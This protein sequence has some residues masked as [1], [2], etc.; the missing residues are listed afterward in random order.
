MEMAQPARK[1][2]LR[3]ATRT[4]APDRP[5]MT[6]VVV[7]MVALAIL[8]PYLLTFGRHAP[9]WEET[10]VVLAAANIGWGVSWLMRRGGPITWL[11]IIKW[12]GLTALAGLALAFAAAATIITLYAR[13]L[14]SIKKLSDYQPKQVTVILDDKGERIGEIFSG[15]PPTKEHR[16]ERRTLVPFDKIPKRVYQAFIATEDEHFWTH[17]GVDYMGIVR[18]AL[19]DLRGGRKEGASTITQQVVK[20]LVL[21]PERT[22][23]RKIQEMILARRLEQHLTKQEILTIYLNE[24]YLGNQRY[25]IEEAARFYFGKDV[26]GTGDQALDIG[27]AAMLAG[28]PKSPEHYAPP[29]DF[30]AHPRQAQAAK[31]RQVHVLKRELDLHMISQADY[32]K[33]RKAPIQI[34]RDPFPKLGSAPEWVEKAREEL[35][36]SYGAG[37]VERMGAEVKTTLDSD[38]QAHAQHALVDGLRAYDHRHHLGQAIHTYKPDRKQGWAPRLERLARQLPRHGPTARHVYKAL[39]LGARDREDEVDVDLGNWP[40]VLVLGGPEDDRFNPPD[41]HGH[42]KSASQR[43]KAGDLIQVVTSKRRPKLGGHAVELPPA[44]EGAVV[45]IETRTRKVRALVGGYQLRPGD[46]D[47]ASTAHRQPGSSFKPFVYAAAIDQ[48]KATA[49]SVINDAPEV[50]DL[51][52]P[53]NYEKEFEGPVRLRV[54]L[55]RSIN[56]VAI[57]VCADVTPQV[58]ADYA[59]K[60]GI[61]SDLPE[62]LSLSLGSGEVTPLELTNAYATFAA[63][64]QYAP[65]RFVDS[66]DGKEPPVTAPVQVL[67]PEVAYVVTDMMRSVVEE[68]TGV[69]VRKVGVPVAGKTGT[70]NDLHDAWFMGM[71][72]DYVIGVWVGFDAPRSLGGHEQGGVTA[73]PVYVE[74]MKAMHPVAKTFARPPGVTDAVIDKATGLLAAP[75]A[76]ADSKMTEVFVDGTQP[77]EVAPLPGQATIDTFVTGEYDDGP[78]AGSGSGSGGDEGI[79][80]SGEDEPDTDPGSGGSEPVKHP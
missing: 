27:E 36:K 48:G 10:L 35:V 60:M 34:V 17:G 43:F 20:N 63:G 42:A 44:P 56:T 52:K 33:Y 72:P 30:K 71:T 25:G 3:P 55:A 5:W 28:L 8:G 64:G 68:G 32:D 65:P 38:I 4:R 49:A 62:E 37:V 58:V 18:A 46:F 73:A 6:Y 41:E 76:P 24:I 59:H 11:R 19:H 21:S 15:E 69:R 78:A 54:A 12:A 39:V 16:P 7:G 57:R 53:H 29:H 74:L 67:R 40:A 70:S 66:I 50:Y 75:D 51:W 80:D 22:F 9:W 31:D 13:G 79:D 45:V 1:R 26:W 2:K 61:Q 77:T 47:R 14:P 23:K